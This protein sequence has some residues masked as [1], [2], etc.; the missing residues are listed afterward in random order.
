[1][2][3]S[4]LWDRASALGCFTMDDVVSVDRN[5]VAQEVW[6]KQGPDVSKLSGKPVRLRMRMRAAKLYA[7]QFVGDL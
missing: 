5:G 7:F 3:S 2:L 6:W 1:M 4:L